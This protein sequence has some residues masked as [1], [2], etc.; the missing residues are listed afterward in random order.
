MATKR[1]FDP[2]GCIPSSKA[3]RRR[4]EEIQEQARRLRILLQTAESIEQHGQS[5][6]AERGR[7][8]DGSNGG[9]A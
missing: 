7:K 3:I 1:G 4:L 5:N 9:K 8:H 2:L 6:G